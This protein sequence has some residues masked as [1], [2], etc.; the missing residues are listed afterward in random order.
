MG[1]PLGRRLTRRKL[2]PSANRLYS[3]DTDNR[4]NFVSGITL[5]VIFS[6]ETLQF[7]GPQKYCI[8]GTVIFPFHA[9]FLFAPS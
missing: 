2:A 8:F 5:V 3:F 7:Y 9:I 4:Q 6:L 1:L